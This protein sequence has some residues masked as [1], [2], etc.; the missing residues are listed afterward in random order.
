MTMYKRMQVYTY[1]YT[2][3][4]IKIMY[5]INYQVS[6]PVEFVE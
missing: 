4:K 1:N 3:T 2:D 6:I 5:D